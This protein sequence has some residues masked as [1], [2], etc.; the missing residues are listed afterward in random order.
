MNYILHFGSIGFCFLIIYVGFVM[1]FKESSKNYHYNYNRIDNYFDFS[2]FHDFGKDIFMSNGILFIVSGFLGWYVFLG[3]AKLKFFPIV[4]FTIALSLFWFTNDST[5]SSGKSYFDDGGMSKLIFTICE[6]MLL[7]SYA[8]MVCYK[9]TNTHI[10][11]EEN[12][13]EPN[14]KIIN[15]DIKE[16]K[17]KP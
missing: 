11:S 5:I 9:K 6:V 14:P 17:E 1:L 12:I 4:I 15:R 7:F 3:D 16:N 2:Y 13:E 10:K 8:F